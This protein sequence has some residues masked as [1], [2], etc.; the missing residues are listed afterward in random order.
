MIL[1][2]S[3][4]QIV[5][6]GKE[7][8]L[9]NHSS[10]ASWVILSIFFFLSWPCCQAKCC[11]N[12]PSTQSWQQI[13]TLDCTNPSVFLHTNCAWCFKWQTIWLCTINTKH[14][15]IRRYIQC[16]NIHLYGAK[17]WT[18]E[19]SQWVELN[20]AIKRSTQGSVNSWIGDF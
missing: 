19:I 5:L 6:V 7:G 20:N 14:G 18:N 11:W 15:L 4:A 9:C 13:Y 16:L 3:S 12:A 8:L 1:I 2:S 17:F 10:F